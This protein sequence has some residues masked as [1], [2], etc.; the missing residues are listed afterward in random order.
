MPFSWRSWTPRADHPGYETDRAPD[1]DMRQL[2]IG[3]ELVDRR[4]RHPK[5][6]RYLR[7]RQ[8][9]IERPE[10]QQQASSKIFENRSQFWRSA[11]RPTHLTLSDSQDLRSG[12]TFCTRGVRSWGA[13]GRWFKSSRPDHK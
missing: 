3:H 12:A 5:P 8:K 10:L 6:P 1:P 2:A 4:P 7:D 11:T 9:V 13:S